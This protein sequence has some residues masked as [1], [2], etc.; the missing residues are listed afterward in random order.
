MTKIS[1]QYSLTN[2]LFADT[3]NGRVGVNN[4]SPTVTLDVTGAGKFS[5]DVT[6]S[7]AQPNSIINYTSASDYGRI[8][9]NE[10]GTFKASIQFMGS[11]FVAT[12]RRN[13]LEIVNTTT[14]DLALGTGDARTFYI[15]N[16]G[17]VGI[18][19]SSPATQ[20]HLYGTSPVRATIEATGGFYAMTR[21]KNSYYTADL[22]IDDTG[23]YLDG[24]TGAFRYYNS[25]GERMRI[26]S[27]GDVLV[28][29]T[30]SQMTAA[31]R[32]L[33][34][35]NG[36]GTT[37]VHFMIA[38][39][40]KG[41]LYH[42]G[43][44]FYWKANGAGNYLYAVAVT[45]GVYLSTN[46][47]SWTANS[48]ERIKDINSQITDAVTTIS[49]LRAVKYSWKSDKTKKLNIG[50]VA[51][52]VQAVLPEIVDV[53]KDEMGTLGVRYTEMIPV[54]VAAIKE[55][56]ADLTSAKQEIELLKAK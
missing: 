15:K 30:T 52:D 19:T 4:S 33:I 16:G 32:G 41:F 22:G 50:L 14:G 53:Q 49:S 44:D 21:L 43:G 47:T 8:Y 23:L 40:D 12:A 17:N 31:N 11:T 42:N 2:V 38:G 28:G 24:S 46:A 26:T 37:A 7:A 34:A 48:D 39:A 1:N 29:T 10:S 51:Q 20:F 3:T 13:A 9:F 5:S 35:V 45:N 27:G 25:G 55:L 54:L 36:A 56:S 18:G 6:I